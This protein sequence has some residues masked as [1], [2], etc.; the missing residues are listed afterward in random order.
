VFSKDKVNFENIIYKKYYIVLL[1]IIIS[2]LISYIININVNAPYTKRYSIGEFA[3]KNIKSP[4]TIQVEDIEATELAR[5]KAENLTPSVYDFDIE[6]VN[7]IK[8][9]VYLTFNSLRQETANKE[10]FNKLLNMNFSTTSYNIIEQNKFS[11]RIERAILYLINFIPQKYIV[12]SVDE[13]FNENKNEILV[14]ILNSEQKEEFRRISLIHDADSFINESE[15]KKNLLDKLNE[16][17]NKFK[18]QEYLMLKE[19]I[20][21]IEVSNFYFNKDKTIE[22]KKQ[23]KDRTKKVIL[24]VKRGEIIVRDG[25]AIEREH[26]LILSELNKVKTEYRSL[27]YFFIFLFLILLSFYVLFMFAYKEKKINFLRHKDILVLAVFLIL[28]IVFL[29]LWYYFSN[30]LVGTF[31]NVSNEVLVYAFPFI[32]LPLIVRLILGTE[33]AALI[34][35]MASI[36]VGF[37]SDASFEISKFFLFSGFSAL[38]FIRQIEERTSILKIGFY[39][40][41]F[42]AIFAGVFAIKDINTIDFA[43]KNVVFTSSLAFSGAIIS[44]LV[45]ES[46]LPIIELLFNYT[47][48]LR[49]L[50]FA[51]TNHKL[52]RELLLKAPGTFNHSMVVGQ[53]ASAGANAIGANTLLCRVGSY[54]HDIGKIGKSNYF[55][56]NQQN[57]INPHDKLNTTMSVRILISHIKDGVKLAKDYKLGKLISNIIEQH[58]GTSLIKFFYNRAIEQELNPNELDYRYPGPNPK[59]KEAV[60]VMLADASEAAVRSIDDPSPTKIQNMVEKIINNMFADGQFDESNITLKMLKEINEVYTKIL[61]SLYHTRIDYPDLLEKDKKDGNNTEKSNK[62]KNTNQT[63]EETS[64][65]NNG[66]INL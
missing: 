42:Q 62:K 51:N 63:F 35:I 5:N 57:K 34:I 30:L 39:V 33:I 29:K 24:Q 17:Q 66:K 64:I 22:L 38:I 3:E 44:A 23:A 13:I 48:N 47:T 41:I 9:K 20:D 28:F 12:K 25:E 43:W 6:A 19:F 18:R 2:V 53:L 49:L 37:I 31:I 7:K 15:V 16:I 4:Q 1:I 11:L 21:L 40:A 52:L 50:E 60:L 58:H 61:I 36:I 14:N 8:K 27:V 32:A 65:T 54:F 55:I 46:L 26:L 59:T 10:L 45:V 56:E